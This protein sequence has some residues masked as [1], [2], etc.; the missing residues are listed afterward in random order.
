MSGQDIFIYVLI[1]IIAVA[2]IVFHLS[3]RKANKNDTDKK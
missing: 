2:F 1:A 3:T